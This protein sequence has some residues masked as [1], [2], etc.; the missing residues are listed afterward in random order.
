M[1]FILRNVFSNVKLETE[2]AENEYFNEDKKIKPVYR[3][4][5]VK[6]M[7]SVGIIVGIVLLSN[8][9]DLTKL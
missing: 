5:L 8:S 2:R 1:V 4:Y 9:P 6:R 3:K 7:I